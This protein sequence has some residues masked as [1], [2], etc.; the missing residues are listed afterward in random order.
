MRRDLGRSTWRW[1]M[2][3]FEMGT[4]RLH[5][6][7][8]RSGAD[9]FQ[10]QCRH[11]ISGIDPPISHSYGMRLFR[12]RIGDERHSRPTSLVT[13]FRMSEDRS[14]LSGSEFAVGIDVGGSSIK[15]A[16]VDCALATVIGE[17][18][19]VPLPNPSAPGAV[20]V[21]IR[22]MVEQI[23][24]TYALIGLPIGMD[25]P[26]VV[27]DG[28][29]RTAANIDNGWIGFDAAA[30]LRGALGRDVAVLNDADAADL[31]EMRFGAGRGTNTGRQSS[32]RA[33]P[34]MRR[35]RDPRPSGSGG[36]P[37]RVSGWSGPRSPPSAPRGGTP[38]ATGR[39]R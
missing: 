3:D 11:A 31:A 15:A 28:V 24:D 1:T 9:P 38:E 16:L 39:P 19:A 12:R 33:A 26:A 5:H 22:D 6:C 17:R 20:V 25:V 4:S 36:S 37:G 7:Q 32:R 10:R 35:G 14:P 30:A 2:R 21:A 13:G 18:V 34:S 23:E 8:R 29:T 27:A